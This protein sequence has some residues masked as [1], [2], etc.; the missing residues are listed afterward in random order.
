MVRSRKD[1]TADSLERQIKK[2]QERVI[3]TKDA[4]DMAVR[5]LQKMLDKRDA[6]RKDKLW[7]AIIKSGKSYDEI[8]RFFRSNPD[9]DE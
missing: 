2:L 6:Q 7:G 8:I 3:K 9:V 5:A 1:T 4:H